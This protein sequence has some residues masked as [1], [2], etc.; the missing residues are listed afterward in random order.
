MVVSLCSTVAFVVIPTPRNSVRPLQ[1]SPSTTEY[2]T[3]IYE[4]KD[5]LNRAAETKREDP[6]LVINALQDL[7]K[8]MRKKAKADPKTAEEMLSC[9]N[10]DWRLVFTTGTADTQKKIQ[11]KINYFPLKVRHASVKWEHCMQSNHLRA[12]GV[13]VGT[14]LTNIVYMIPISLFLYV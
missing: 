4:A 12:I 3:A 10:G 11:G 5:I 13:V 6:E 2:D 1:A 7:E 8:L 9:L 14:K